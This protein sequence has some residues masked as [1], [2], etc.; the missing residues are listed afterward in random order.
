MKRLKRILCLVLV[1]CVAMGCTSATAGSVTL[2]KRVSG[3]A[4][5]YHHSEEKTGL[6]TGRGHD[7]SIQLEIKVQDGLIKSIEVKKSNE[8]PDKGGKAIKKMIAEMVEKNTIE[9]DTVSKATTT[10]AAVLQAAKAALADAGVKAEDLVKEVARCSATAEGFGGDVTVKLA[11]AKEYKKLLDVQ[12]EG[13]AETPDIGGKAMEKL[14]ENMFA[15]N[16]VLFDSIS[17]ATYTS[18]AVV[19]AARKALESVGLDASEDFC[20][21]GQG[22]AQGYGGPVNVTLTLRQE[23]PGA[24]MIPA[25]IVTIS[26]EGEQETPDIG[27]EALRKLPI[28]MHMD[29][30]LFVDGVSGATVTSNAVKDAATRALADACLP[31]R[32]HY[33]PKNHIGLVGISLHD[34]FPGL[35]DKWYNVVPVD[36]TVQGT[37]EYTLIAGNMFMIGKVNVTVQEDYVTVSYAYNDTVYE[38]ESECMKWFKNVNEI[39]TEFFENPTSDMKFGQPVSIKNDLGGQEVALLFIRN[40]A[41]YGLRSSQGNDLRYD[42]NLKKW[43]DYRSELYELMKRI[44]E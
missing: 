17:G 27:G 34:E 40:V 22:T 19:S 42:K 44:P 25:N 7:G 38:V 3:G 26:A 15:H 8:T 28:D 11:I 32:R 14:A 39:T 4:N 5:V 6:G 21:I 33:Y 37:R 31:P 20:L 13:K 24:I 10:S 12:I 16:A 2:N 30:Y 43:Q 41:S 29:H 23:V 1:L 9:V 36:L 18:Q 35:T